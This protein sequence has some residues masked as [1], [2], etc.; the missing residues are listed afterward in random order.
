MMKQQSMRAMKKTCDLRLT[1]LPMHR[2][3]QLTKAMRK[4]CP[5]QQL[6]DVMS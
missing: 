3:A 4:I 5:L 2:L 1:Q 6:L